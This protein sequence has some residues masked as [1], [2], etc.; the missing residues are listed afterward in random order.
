M[1]HL[2]CSYRDCPLYPINSN[3][4]RFRGTGVR[5][6]GAKGLR[7]T[8]ESSNSQ[9]PNLKIVQ[10]QKHNLMMI[11]KLKMNMKQMNKYQ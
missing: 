1:N 10:N 7:S 5:I 2:R 6:V 8:L 4:S 9:K 11:K 3:H